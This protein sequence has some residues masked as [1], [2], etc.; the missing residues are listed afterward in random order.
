MLLKG[1]ADVNVKSTA[2]ET[3]LDW[4]LKFHHPGVLATLRD[5]GAVTAVAYTAPKPDAAPGKNDPRAAVEK[6]VALLQRSNTEFF[7][8]SGCVGCH[9][10]N[11]TAMA[12][13][14]ARA[15]GVRVDEAADKEQHNVTRFGWATMSESML[16]RLDPPGG[17]DMVALSLFGLGAYAHQPDAVSDAMVFDVAAMQRANGSWSDFGIS[18]APV[19]ESNIARTTMGLRCLQL[20]GM[21]GRQAEFD[22]RI[23]RARA[24]LQEAKPVTNDDFAMRVMGLVW[25]NADPGAIRTAAHQLA[26]RQ[27]PDGGWAQNDHAPSDAFATGE[28]L[29][30]L[31]QAR[32]IAPADPACRQAVNFLTASQFAD[33]SWYVRSKAPK[34]QPYFQS[35]FP[36][37]HDQWISATATAWAAMAISGSIAPQSA[38]LR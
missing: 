38:A 20:F 24:W 23:N 9:H 19:S 36:F 32:A 3:V 29:W 28:S 16:Q 5:S 8:Q 1:G 18:R 34:F 7:K 2:G 13:R 25:S 30:A 6:A 4:A 17:L 26:G 37:D 27:R 10:Q 21:P 22:E 14:S 11:F 15:G 31:Q 33:G 12:V 35:G